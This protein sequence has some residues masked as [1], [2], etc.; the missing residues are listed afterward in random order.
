[1]MLGKDLSLGFFASTLGIERWKCVYLGWYY[2]RVLTGFICQHMYYVVVYT[3]MESQ[4][5]TFSNILASLIML[6]IMS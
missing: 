3:I 2:V 5:I 4:M 1:V 6:G